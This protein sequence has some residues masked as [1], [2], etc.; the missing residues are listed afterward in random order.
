MHVLRIQAFICL[1]A[2]KKRK[3]KGEK[4]VEKIICKNILVLSRRFVLC[5]DSRGLAAE[6]ERSL[7]L[8][9]PSEN[10]GCK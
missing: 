6:W 9:Q 10:I 3:K 1:G 2:K 4:A 8:M 7:T 5:T